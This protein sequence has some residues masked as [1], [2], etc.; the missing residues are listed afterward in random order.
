[1][2]KAGRA[3]KQ[4]SSIHDRNRGA[5]LSIRTQF[6]LFSQLCRELIVGERLNMKIE[7]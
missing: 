5:I 2:K 7:I 4:H 1:M 6:Y 3:A